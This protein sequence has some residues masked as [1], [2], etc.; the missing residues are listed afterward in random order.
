MNLRDVAD[1]IEEHCKSKPI[2]RQRKI[3]IHS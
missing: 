3:A 2:V 1:T